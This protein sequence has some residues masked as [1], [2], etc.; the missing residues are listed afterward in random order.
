[1]RIILSIH[2]TE[3][4]MFGDSPSD[5][6]ISAAVSW[7]LVTWGGSPISIPEA[8]GFSAIW[9]SSLQRHLKRCRFCP[10]A[11]RYPV[12]PNAPECLGIAL[13]SVANS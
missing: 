9:R 6:R 8:K 12:I 13:L 3:W 11:N 10:T 7:K 4:S 2:P 5:I 1:M